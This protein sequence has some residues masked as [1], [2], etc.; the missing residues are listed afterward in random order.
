MTSFFS[1][2][3]LV[4][5]GC[6]ILSAKKPETMNRLLR[7][8]YS[9]KQLM[10]GFGSILAL[11]FIMVGITDPQTY[12]APQE[13]KPQEKEQ[14]QISPED[15]Q[16]EQQRQRDLVL[17]FAEQLQGT[18]KTATEAIS[19]MQDGLDKLATGKATIYD[20]YSL[21]KD[22]KTACQNV[23]LAYQKL[24]VP[25]DLPDDVKKHLSKAKS[26]ASTAYYAKSEGLDSA[27]RFLDNQKPSDL[28]EYKDKIA[29]S[30]RFMISASLELAEAKKLVGIE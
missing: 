17:A 3:A 27:L 30:N 26:E 5:I 9:K 29:Q 21:T 7:K 19:K 28:Q 13:N 2:I 23:M 4:A 20:V 14:V 22:A 25:N 18:D 6:M 10:W 8:T 1:V 15:Q 12:V 16:K 24:S 11:S